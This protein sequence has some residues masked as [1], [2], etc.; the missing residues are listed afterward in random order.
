MAKKKKD[1]KIYIPLM[2]V[3]A[4]VIVGG[5]YWFIDYN[6]FIRTDDAYVT[7]DVVTVSPK[8]MGRVNK[9]YADEGDTVK[10]GELLAELDSTDI[11]AQKQQIIAGK[12]QAE[13]GK[14]QTEAKYE[15]DVKNNDV[16][17]INLERANEDFNRAKA[18]YAGEVITKE[19]YDH[20]KKAMETAKAQFDA[21][22]A[23]LKVSKTMI[24]SAQTAIV[25]AQAQINTINTQLQ[26]TRLYAPSS[27]VIP[28]TTI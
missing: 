2:V 5:I 19:Q 13:A 27:G 14:M 25:S 17:K 15:F 10:Q 21:A 1:L 26:N 3:I 16:L 24:E 11:L 28:S 7:S 22:K 9:I 4:L 23:Q 12:A 20:L 8:I 18:Q 6:S